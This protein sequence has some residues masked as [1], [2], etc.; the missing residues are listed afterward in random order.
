MSGN[1]KLM[2]KNVLGAAL[3][4]SF[5]AAPAAFAADAAK[6]MYVGIGVGQSEIRDDFGCG[7]ITGCSSD[8][9][10]TAWRMYGGMQIL[11]L[12]A[13]E[14]G[15]RDLGEGKLD[16]T[17]GSDK[18]KGKGVDMTAIGTLSVTDTITVM[19]RGGL[20]RWAV[21]TDSDSATGIS[22][23]YGIG[24]KFSLTKE[25]ALRADWER[26]KN[27]GDYNTTGKSDVNTWTLG[28]MF[29]F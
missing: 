10:D 1:K 28:A 2:V 27:L 12:L 3:A 22:P 7:G 9:K 15:Y 4:L 18:V 25:V 5:V 8:N 14:M 24:A 17:G 13:V 20:M 16:Y 29:S 11:D 19:G 23:L 21:D 6:N 26:L